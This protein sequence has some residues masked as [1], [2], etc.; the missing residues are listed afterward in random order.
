MKRASANS[1]PRRF[2]FHG[3]AVAAEVILTSIGGQPPPK[4]S[5]VQGQSSL[6]T[7]GGHSESLVPSSDPAFAN[8]FSYGECRT[9]AD[10]VLNGDTAVTT[11]S[12]SV[13]SIR[14]TNRPSP[15]ETP[16]PQ[17][18]E[19]HAGRLALAMRSTHPSQGQAQIEFSEPPV[20]EKLSLAGRPLEIELRSRLMSLARLSDL[21]HAFRTD[22]PFFDDCRDAF[23]LPDPTHP[24]AFGSGLPTFRNQY[25]VT[26]IV[27]RIVWGDQTI[28]G[29][30]LSLT[31]FGTIY[32]GE[33]LINEYNRRVTL[34][35]MKLGSDVDAEASF[36][37]GDPNGTFYPPVA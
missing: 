32:F 25:V 1:F 4:S 11:L 21:D 12:S 35:R 14:V 23:M 19:F 24:P 15:G 29:H 33:L 37:E 34:V 6:P 18:I 30:V 16:A 26:S 22:R 17:P 3:N 28:E 9:Q 8:V 5:Q 2:V 7:I 13:Q 20:F 36:S 10:G 27:R 31:G